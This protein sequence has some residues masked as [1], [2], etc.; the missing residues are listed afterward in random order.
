[1]TQTP[2][3]PA[4]SAPAPPAPATSASAL[5]ADGLQA[6]ARLLDPRAPVSA[7]AARRIRKEIFG[8]FLINRV[9]ADLL[10]DLAAR[11]TDAGAAWNELYIEAIQDFVLNQE[12]PLLSISDEETSWLISRLTGM[13]R[14]L[15]DADFELVIRLLERAERAPERFQRFALHSVLTLPLAR[16]A[17]AASDVVRIR[18]VLFA[19]GSAGGVAIT[20]WEAEALFELADASAQSENASEWNDLFAR[21]IGCHVMGLL[22]PPPASEAE[23]LRREA[24]LNAPADTGGFL[25]RMVP[26]SWKDWLG[27]LGTDPQAEARAE[28]E[29]RSVAI[30]VAERI[31]S[32]ESQ[33]LVDRLNRDGTRSA[34]EIALLAFL[35][36]EV[37]GLPS[38]LRRLA[39]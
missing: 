35:E 7:E 6:L 9:E 21:A 36:R 5:P 4:P 23:M 37:P 14:P 28:A 13:G 30:G 31:T 32:L 26:V 18:R 29:A 24:W 33:W 25:A 3:A 34:A 15:E 8:D 1:M 10:F 27:L 17:V 16:K 19:L 39:A 22:P 2:P 20:Q 12:Q 11:V 38:E